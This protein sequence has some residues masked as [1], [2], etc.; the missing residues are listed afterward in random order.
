MSQTAD[1]LYSRVIIEFISKMVHNS[2]KI[3]HVLYISQWAL[4]THGD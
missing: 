1:V 2:E 3:S 4:T